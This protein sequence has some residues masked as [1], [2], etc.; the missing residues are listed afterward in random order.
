MKLVLLTLALV[1]FVMSGVT[2]FPEPYALWRTRLIA[3]GLAAWV[4]AN[5]PWP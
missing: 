2:P 5:Y 1:L 4:A 3:L